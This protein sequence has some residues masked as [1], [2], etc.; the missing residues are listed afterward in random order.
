MILLPKKNLNTL[1]Q[2]GIKYRWAWK[3]VIDQFWELNLIREPS[4]IFNLNYNKI[5]NLEGWGEL[6]INNLK[7]IKKSQTIALINL[8]TQ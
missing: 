4:D 5:K 8:L 7:A 6:S 3:K 2:K 1:Y